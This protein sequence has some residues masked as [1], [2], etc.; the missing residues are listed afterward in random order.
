MKRLNKPNKSSLD[1]RKSA[2]L[3]QI[4]SPNSNKSAR[5]R[6]RGQFRR[7]SDSSRKERPRWSEQSKSAR[8]WRGSERR[9]QSGQGKRGNG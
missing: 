9:R 3:R 1:C 7:K 2:K 6:Q 8:S 4:A 5:K